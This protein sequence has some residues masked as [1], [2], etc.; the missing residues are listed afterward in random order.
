[1]A[2]NQNG[3]KDMSLS[4][5]DRISR[6]MDVLA[7]ALEAVVDQRMTAALGTDW[8]E[9]QL[10]RDARKSS[11][12][13]MLSKQDPA[14]LLNTIMTN[15]GLA[16]SR[17][18]PRETRN[19]AGELKEI[20]NKWAHGTSFTTDDTSR[21]LDT[22][23]RLLT[24][25]G[26]PTHAAE[27]RKSRLDMNRESVEKETKRATREAA[28]TPS[29]A[30]EGIKPW[31]EVLVP[32]EDVAKGNFNASEYAANL[33]RAAE[34][35]GA[36]EYTDPVEFFRRTYLTEGLRELLGKALKR[37]SGDNNASPTINLQTNFGGGKT[38]S[39][40]ALYHLFAP[41]LAPKV[42]PQEVQELIEESGV[43]LPAGEVRRVVL[44]GTELTPGQPD[45]KSD[46]TAVNTLWGELAWQLGGKKAFGILAE[47][48]ANGTNPGSKLN[49][50]LAAYAPCLI[51]VDEWVAYARQLADV[52][53]DPETGKPRVLPAGS[54]ET[55][56]TFAQTLTEAVEATVGAILVVSIPAS[57]DSKDGESN[58]SDLETGG[59]AGREALAR[60]QNV[61][62]RKADQWRPAAPNESF[63]IVRRR[64]FEFASGDVLREIN[65]VA[66]R[67]RQFYE[68]NSKDFPAEAITAEYEARIRAAYPLHPELFDRL[69][70]DW[71]T[72]ERFQRTRGVLRLMSQVIHALWVANDASPMIMPGSVPL[73][74]H[75]VA[76]ELTQY[77]EDRWKPIL[78][79][80]IDGDKSTPVAIDTEKTFLGQRAVTRR[81]ARTIFLG[82]AATLKAAHKGIDEQRIRLGV[83]M[84]GD[85]LGNFRTA[86]NTLA[87]R[88]TYL[89]SDD[90]RYW[91]DT[92]ATVTRTAK[93]YAE[94][95][96]DRQEE[97]WEEIIGRLKPAARKPGDFAAVHVAP[98]SS[99]DIPDL[100]TAR[101]VILHP[102]YTH[103]RGAADSTARL[104]AATALDTVG[105]GQ[106]SR[107][108]TL[109][110][111]AADA[112]EAE[113]LLA[114][115][116]D[117]MAWRYVF[118]NADSLELSPGPRK[119][120]ESRMKSSNGTVNAKIALTYQWALIPEQPDAA[121]PI[122][123]TDTK[124]DTTS[125]DLAV[126]TAAK[127]VN[128]Q[129]LM[130][131]QA[132]SLI[133]MKLDGPLARSS[134][135][136]GH[137]TVGD[138]W[139]LHVE[140][141]YMNRLTNRSVLNNGIKDGLSVILW[142]R[143]GFALA[144]GYDEKTGRYQGLALRGDPG[145]FGT[146]TDSTLLVRPDIAENQ[147]AVDLAEEEARERPGPGTADSAGFT[148][149]GGSGA[150]NTRPLDGEEHDG[151][152]TSPAPQPATK[153]TRFYSRAVLT[154]EQYSKVANKIT[155]EIAPHLLAEG[156]EVEISIEIHAKNPDGY[157]DAKI[158]TIKENART[159][160]LDTAEFEDE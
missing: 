41:K 23:E 26:A 80:D 151:P 84:P 67:F 81:V 97:V 82:S 129:Q 17:S 87:D 133:R 120:A 35:E 61:V 126:R 121:R 112:R 60:L 21:A 107:R 54:F 128:D 7:S 111:L 114:D 118:D 83:A 74:V 20:R 56:F 44:V 105:S 57:H 58:S 31:R 63:E 103:R 52:P 66:R 156:A 124:V 125:L 39:M 12:E 116:M 70:E 95:L 94:R 160:K 99:R 115:T 131:H 53:K 122:T 68:Q 25:I 77:L 150:G 144:T 65:A 113:S 98:T 10:E 89:Y 49:D 104:F 62:R 46:G 14:L 86:I 50:V 75:L 72:L 69:Y 4:N 48:D 2:Q 91:Y 13:S 88:A 11:V 64:L 32:H 59:E 45:V 3:N 101:L 33:A 28:A 24:A 157:S 29:I 148:P 135:K 19:F 55:Q 102:Q 159:L 18:V 127:L 158:R 96:K 149:G 34:G 93:D 47:S 76:N 79:A 40:L 134:W 100:E 106:R 8:L 137:I 16:F 42:L 154:P 22:G 90:D 146:I 110:F 73:N 85:T 140:F 15:W 155:M 5:R 36:P 147:R 6:M 142:E 145:E 152:V 136:D 37:I 43:G 132:P 141:P 78:D 119:Q 153:K 123:W 92:Q 109:V 138:L 117:F 108:N 139:K 1:M 143:E 27:V 51:L 38:H 130:P 30:A 71:S 9:K